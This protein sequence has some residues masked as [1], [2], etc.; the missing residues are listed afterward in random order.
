MSRARERRLWALKL[1]GGALPKAADARAEAHA[2][3]AAGGALRLGRRFEG[4]LLGLDPSLRGTGWGVVDCSGQGFQL[5]AS[6]TL[7]QPSQRAQGDCLADIQTHVEALI[8]A[9][10]PVQVALEATIF[11]QSR[12]TV[13]QLGMVRGILLALAARHALPCHDYAPR[14]IKQAVS[15]RGQATKDEVSRQ[16]QSLLKLDAA[17]PYDA[18]DAVAAALCHALTWR[19]APEAS[20]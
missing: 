18:S 17:L 4:R 11:V 3:A 6:G 10:R 19:A 20:A 16:V 13:Y 9:H 12:Q 5:V 14:A 7:R 8:Q 2:Q 1:K 15:G